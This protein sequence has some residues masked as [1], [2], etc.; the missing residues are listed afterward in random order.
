M[1]VRISQNIHVVIW[2]LT[3]ADVKLML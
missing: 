1:N 2:L 3:E